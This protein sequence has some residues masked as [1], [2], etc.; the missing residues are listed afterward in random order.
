MILRVRKSASKVFGDA[1]P[2]WDVIKG[3]NYAHMIPRD[4]SGFLCRDTVLSSQLYEPAGD[5]WAVAAVLYYMLT[6]KVPGTLKRRDTERGLV[7]KR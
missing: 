5:V 1:V 2:K 6:G 3:L 4:F 7:L